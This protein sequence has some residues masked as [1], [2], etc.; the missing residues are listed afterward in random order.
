MLRIHV[1]DHAE[2]QTTTMTERQKQAVM[3]LANELHRLNHAVVKAVESG[4]SIELQRVARHHAD[5]GYWGDLMIP[6]V[7]KQGVERD[8][9]IILTA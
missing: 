6:V 4:L 2:A 8:Q 7:V 3:T 1:R 5:G 9:V